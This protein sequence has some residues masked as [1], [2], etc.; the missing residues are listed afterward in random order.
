[1]SAQADALDRVA[2]ELAESNRLRREAQRDATRERDRQATERF[3][4]RATQKEPTHVG[5][6]LFARAVPVI[7][8]AFSHKIPGEFWTQVADRV[9]DVACPCGEAPRVAYDRIATCNCSRS[10]LYDGREVRVANSPAKGADTP[11]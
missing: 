7:A 3:L 1:M 4:R 9:V 6:G 10:Y 11:A 8:E 5:V 2:A